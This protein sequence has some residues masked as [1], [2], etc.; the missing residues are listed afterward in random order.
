MAFDV[1]GARS[2]GYSD[3]EIVE[4]LSDNVKFDVSGALN[5]GYSLPEIAD[6]MSGLEF[7]DTSFLGSVG[8]AVRRIPGGLARGITSTFTG[9]GQL[10]PVLMM[11]S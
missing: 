1:A 8:E 9:A 7:D 10:I 2:E 6:Y 5:A 3:R 4:Y 11:T